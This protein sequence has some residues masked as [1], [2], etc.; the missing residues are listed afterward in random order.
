MRTP[1]FVSMVVAL[2]V[3]ACATTA[4]GV[5]EKYRPVVRKGLEWLVKQ[6]EA[7]G[8]WSLSG[9]Q[10]SVAATSFAGLALLSEGSTLRDGKC[11]PALRRAADWLLARSDRSDSSSDGLIVDHG[12]FGG[13]SHYMFGHGYAMLFLSAACEDATGEQRRKIQDVLVQ[14]MAFAAK[15]Q[16]TRG[17]WGYIT[18][19]DGADFDEG[20]STAAVIQGL[21][22]AHIAG[23]PMQRGLLDRAH[24]YLKNSTEPNGGVIYSLATGGSGGAGRPALTAA[25]IASNGSGDPRSP[26]VKKWYKFSESSLSSLLIRRGWGLGD[27][28]RF[29]GTLAVYTLGDEGYGKLFPGPAMSDRLIWTNFR[30]K[31]FAELVAEQ[32]SDGSWSGT[33]LGPV[34]A[35]AINLI[36]LQLDNEAIPVQRTF[37]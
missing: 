24:K 34:F 6:Q 29:Y 35:T 31:L 20:A 14:A 33:T 32:G 16:T 2:T 7:D 36:L 21:T 25:A 10:Y 3:S 12:P 37:R 8:H 17:G 23:I 27:Y 26:L 4:D 5:P 13:D 19:R 30:N 22:A 15:A 28:E 11:A 9:G 1:F 18:A